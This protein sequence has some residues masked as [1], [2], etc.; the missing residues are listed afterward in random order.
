MAVVA[1][2]VAI[3]SPAE[4][5]GSSRLDPDSTLR[6]R[7]VF[8]DGATTTV[9]ADID[10]VTTPAVSPDG[11]RVAFAG[12]V[13]DESLGLFALFVVDV[14]GTGLEQVTAGSYGEFDPAWSP[15]G[16]YITFSQNLSGSLSM[17]ACCRLARL[18]LE[19]GLVA[20][21]TSSN[22]AVRPSVSPDGSLVAFDNPSGVWTMPAAGGT[23]VLRIVNGYDAS[24]SP[25]SD[26]LV[27]VINVNGLRRLRTY[28]IGTGTIATLAT[29]GGS[30]ESPVW[31]G[32]RIYFVHH[33]GSGYDGRAGVEV[34]SVGI[35]GTGLRT[36][37][38]IPDT[39]VGYD[40]FDNDEALFYEA[41]NGD[42]AY[43]DLSADASLGA[44]TASG[45]YSTGWDSITAVDLDGNGHDEIFFYRPVDGVFKYY[46][47]KADGS[48]GTALVSGTYS[49]GWDSITAVDL[50]GD[51]DDE[52]FFYRSADG[53][54]K[55]YETK[56]DGSLGTLLKS[57]SYSL[58]WDS[59][60]AVDLNA[61]G[62]D[63]L[64]FYRSTD[65]IFKYYATKPDG[66]LGTLLQSGA[67][68]L[69]WDVITAIDLTGD[70]WDEILFYRSLDGTFKYYAT[71]PTG[72]LGVLIDTGFYSTGLDAISAVQLDSLG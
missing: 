62:H 57:G 27:Y 53:V 71:Q 31:R 49:T 6:Y 65:G 56:V 18:D 66:S 36:E 40:V 69:G 55:Y 45:A 5:D 14:D 13:G 8:V 52:I 22:G 68:S 23:A 41:S 29:T 60:S 30:F 72:S 43:Y 42:F 24:F 4:G 10:S 37:A 12:S 3:P 58:G 11:A 16:R 38:S 63:E 47:T 61:D 46:Q 15:D 39:G 21:L 64:L 28:D 26:S 67:Y 44:P 51:G 54:F 7:P 34:R 20:G 70:G 17:S 9:L 33:T 35:D 59:I 48:L 1:A 32:G 50:N 25:D 19:T 2:L